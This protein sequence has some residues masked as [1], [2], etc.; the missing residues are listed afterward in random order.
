M[1]VVDAREYEKSI[2]EFAVGV[3]VCMQKQIPIVLNPLTEPVC[4][5]TEV[6]CKAQLPGSVT[7]GAHSELGVQRVSAELSLM[8]YGCH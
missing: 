4:V 8:G 7:K 6:V 2:E 1:R 5:R 3:V